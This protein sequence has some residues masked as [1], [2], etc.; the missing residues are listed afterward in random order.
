MSV[1]RSGVDE[2]LVVWGANNIY[3]LRLPDGAQLQHTRIK[4]KILG[5][6]RDDHNPL[7]P[8][9]I[10]TLEPG[11]PPRILARVDRR[12]RLSR[13]NRKTHR[14]QTIA[15]NVDLVV[16]VTSCRTPPYKH[17]FVDRVLA[18]AEMEGATPVCVVNK[19]DL[20]CSDEAAHHQTVLRRLGYEVIATV[21]ADGGSDA[22][23][24]EL[25]ELLRG[26]VT[27]LFGQSGV[28]KSTLINALIPGAREKTA[29]VSNAT[30]HGR[31][32]TTR[33]T[34][35]PLG[36]H[37]ESGVIDTPGVRELD[38]RHR[39]PDELAAGFREFVPLIPACRYPGCSH[40]HEPDCAVRAAVDSGTIDE[41]RYRSY[42]R[43]AHE[44]IAGG[45]A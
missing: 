10:V 34:L 44:S 4:G 39:S 7:A 40:L 13:W 19:A 12:N 26:R 32:T 31:H 15:A 45:I 14:V 3:T 41:S 8:G 25:A 17:H 18:L 43:L 1:E 9:D 42:E 16:V 23:V 33:A 28:G 24:A 30:H 5:A 29:P 27:V 37:P 6:G 11:R 2:A 36:V 21:A 20:A 22:G 38:L 35:I